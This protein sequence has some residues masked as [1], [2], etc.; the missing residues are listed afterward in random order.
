[1]AK[2]LEPH[3]SSI[4]QVTVIGNS[5]VASTTNRVLCIFAANCGPT[6][7]KEI[8][9]QTEF[10]KVY[11]DGSSIKRR[12]HRSFFH[13][14]KHAQAF[15]LL[16]VR[17]TADKVIKGIT[18]KGTAVYVK[19]DKVLNYA[20]ASTLVVT[21]AEAAEKT[22]AEW[23]I[24]VGDLL[25][26]TDV[27]KGG[28]EYQKLYDSSLTVVSID[29]EYNSWGNDIDSLVYFFT[30]IKDYVMKFANMVLDITT[31]ST[32]VT[33]S[34][35]RSNKSTTVK[36]S[37]NN[38]ELA[39]A[40]ET[41]LSGVNFVIAPNYPS[42][43]NIFDASITDV[44]NINRDGSVYQRFNLNVSI[45]GETSSYLLSSYPD[46]IDASGSNMYL[47]SVNELT[48]DFCIIPVLDS[49]EITSLA[50]TQFGATDTV[51]T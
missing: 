30:Y 26:C 40:T 12:S 9:N 17:V 10:L 24:K 15:P 6:E 7:P 47:T 13:A 48:E 39:V 11:T 46:D 35:V 41:S 22:N 3:T 8:A 1:M 4:E 16:C 51:T 2:N 23:V 34:N 32:S 37:F 31:T 44:K 38:T 21:L 42:T 14:L 50:S 27:A 33:I 19:G 29:P 20:S 25:F 43:T 5:T 45:K 18:N 49:A 36:G 28:T